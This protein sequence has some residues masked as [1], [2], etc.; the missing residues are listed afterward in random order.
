[1]MLGWLKD[2]LRMQPQHDGDAAIGEAM[3]AIRDATVKFG[4]ASFHAGVAEER[5]RIA[6]ILALPLAGRLPERALALALVDAVTVEQ[7]GEI[8]ASEVEREALLMAPQPPESAGHVL[9]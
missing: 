2:R 3:V 1:M 5:A 9:H 7:A 6:A 8:L 4:A